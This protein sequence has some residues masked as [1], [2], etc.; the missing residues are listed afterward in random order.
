MPCDLIFVVVCLNSYQ[1]YLCFCKIFLL[2]WESKLFLPVW[3]QC[4][5]LV[6]ARD[7]KW[8]EFTCTHPTSP[9]RIPLPFPFNSLSIVGAML[10]A[11]FEADL[12][13][14]FISSSSPPFQQTKKEYCWYNNH[15]FRL[16]NGWALFCWFGFKQSQLRLQTTPEPPFKHT[17]RCWMWKHTCPNYLAQTLTCQFLKLK[18]V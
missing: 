6:V 1:E 2:L 10:R 8:Q 12:R 4:L 15:I 14:F 9:T 5:T 18:S 17:L 7:Q 13:P 3:T 16:R 11:L